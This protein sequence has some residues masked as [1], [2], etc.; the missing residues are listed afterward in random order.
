MLAFGIFPMSHCRSWCGEPVNGFVSDLST[1]S[2]GVDWF[3]F[4]NSSRD[5]V[6]RA[7]PAIAQQ[8]NATIFWLAEWTF[9]FYCQSALLPAVDERCLVAIDHKV[10]KR[11]RQ[12]QM[13]NCGDCPFCG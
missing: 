6:Y 2:H 3:L 9:L 12:R 8:T 7:A 13:Q 4:L 5:K 11:M 10:L 1:G